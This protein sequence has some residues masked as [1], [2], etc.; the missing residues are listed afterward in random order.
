M[1]NVFKEEGVTLKK[2]NWANEG[3]REMHS[4]K[5]KE[6]CSES[7]TED[8]QKI[9]IHKRIYVRSSRGSIYFKFSNKILN[10]GKFRKY[11]EYLHTHY[12]NEKRLMPGYL[13]VKYFLLYVAHLKTKP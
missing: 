5:L 2:I 10:K 6:L 11:Y 3:F 13:F 12:Q 4:Q 1:R 8:N 7:C 9:K